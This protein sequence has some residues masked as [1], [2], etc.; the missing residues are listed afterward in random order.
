MTLRKPLRLAAFA[1]GAL[2]TTTMAAQAADLVRIG[3]PTKTYWP[4]ILV[5]AGIE[6]GIFEKEGLE[7]EMTIYRGGAETFEAVAADS[8]DIGNVAAALVAIARTRGVDTKLVGNGADEWSG[9]IL[10]VKTDSPITDPKELDGKNVGITSAGS[11][12]DQLALWAQT[13]SGVEFNRVPVGGGGLVPNLLNDNL[14]AAVIYSPLSYQEV[15]NGTVRVLVDFAT[16]MPPNLT[17]GWAVKD[18]TL[19]ERPDF[20]R[21][22]LNAIYGS[23]QFMLDNRDYAIDLIA[24]NNELPV[25]IATMEYDKTFGRLSRDGQMTL[26]SVQVALDMAKASGAEALAPAEDIFHNIDIQPTMP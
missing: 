6:N 3:V 11:G 4:T 26:D 1:A 9:W 23:L 2:L 16:A 25:E 19:E 13:Q 24:T 5:T 21:R 12:T 20:V 18:S 14:D 22:T 7:A 10:G 8:A 15:A 17:G